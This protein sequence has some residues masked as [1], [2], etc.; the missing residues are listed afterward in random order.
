MPDLVKTILAN[1]PDELQ[2][3][4]GELFSEVITY[5]FGVRDSYLIARNDGRFDVRMTVEA[6]KL[7]THRLGEQTSAVLDWPLTVV[8]EDEQGTVLHKGTLL[9]TSEEQAFDIT[10]DGKPHTI[11]LDPGFV[12]PAA[13]T[14]FRTRAVGTK[15][16]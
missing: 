1:V 3:Q 12:L 8:I 15:P 11:K 7:Y 4:V 16:S 9:F 10:L 6:R 13:H 5:Y 14:P 2:Q